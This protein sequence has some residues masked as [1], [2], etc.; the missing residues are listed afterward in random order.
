MA[1]DVALS[2]QIIVE[3]CASERRSAA[4][5]G[6]CCRFTPN[7]AW[8]TTVRCQS[9]KNLKS[10]VVADRKRLKNDDENS[11][12]N[13]STRRDERTTHTYTHHIYEQRHY[14]IQQN[15]DLRSYIVKQTRLLAIR[16]QPLFATFRDSYASAPF[17][18]SSSRSRRHVGRL[19]RGPGRDRDR[20]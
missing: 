19:G 16:R 17:P 6:H 12:A 1:A 3:S 9:A 4:K 8:T 5:R 13:T 7:S 14:R 2:T 10:T 20:R 18:S 15:L 11:I